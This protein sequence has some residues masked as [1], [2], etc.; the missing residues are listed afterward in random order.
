MK[1]R[2]AKQAPRS[3]TSSMQLAIYRAVRK[4]GQIG[5]V[6]RAK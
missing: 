3:S 1:K 6:R 5:G 2:D 4:S